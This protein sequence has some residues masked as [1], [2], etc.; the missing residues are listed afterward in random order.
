VQLSLRGQCAFGNRL[1]PQAEEVAG[2]LYTV[3]GYP[4][5]IVA[6]DSVII[7]SA[8]Y[9]YHIPR[10]FGIESEPRQLF[11]QPFRY[12]PQYVYGRPDWD[13]ILK[14]FIDAGRTINS[15]RLSFEHD[16]T[17]VGVGIGAELQF[18]RNLNVRVDWGFALE[19]L[20]SANV[21]AGDNRVHFVATIL[22]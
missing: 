1:I 2:G 13:L 22:F 4:E 14:A 17:L 18:K 12:A 20:K 9:R 11:G 19:D 3:R 10:A 5:S 8:E 21:Q 6:G 15:D 16:E 7:G